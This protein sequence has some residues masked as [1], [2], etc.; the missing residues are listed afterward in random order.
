VLTS[1]AGFVILEKEKPM[2]MLAS[3][4]GSLVL[5]KVKPM[6]MV[7]SSV[8]SFVLEKE[9]AGGGST[10]LLVSRF[11]FTVTRLL[12]WFRLLFVFSL[13]LL[14]PSA[15]LFF[16]LSSL[17]FFFMSR[18]LILLLLFSFSLSV[19]LLFLLPRLG[20]SS[21][22]YSQRMHALLHENSNGRR[23]LAVKRSP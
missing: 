13:I 23:A 9:R 4:A 10:P 15:S 14:N 20:L 5:K 12:C 19:V 22:F 8:I 3:S 18:C 11:F 2:M 21:G 7:A 17:C 6:V 16:T 1:S